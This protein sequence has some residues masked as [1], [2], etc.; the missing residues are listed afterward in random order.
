MN[1]KGRY[2]A[3]G[4]VATMVLSSGVTFGVMNYR[5]SSNQTAQGLN[6]PQFSKLVSAYQTLKQN[7]Y[8]DVKSDTLLNGAIDGMVKS[9]DDPY[10]E[11]MDP[12]E[13]Q[14]FQENI[15][16]S[17]EGIG[18][19]IKAENGHIM[20]V[21]P[22]KG[23]PAEKAGLKPNDIILKVDGTSLDNMSVNDA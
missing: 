22:I 20:I 8:Q 12:K 14:S 1:I 15:S 16:S 5:N 10:S 23:S 6:D 7:Y 21:S 2:I 18:A 9:L 13:A 4:L 19:E 3:L 11:Y 17:F